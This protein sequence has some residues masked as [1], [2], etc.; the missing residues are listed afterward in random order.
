[1]NG[2]FQL[3]L[4]FYKPD[5]GKLKSDYHELEEGNKFSLNMPSMQTQLTS[6]WINV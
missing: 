3:T 6:S 4:L 1:M 5:Y 2:N